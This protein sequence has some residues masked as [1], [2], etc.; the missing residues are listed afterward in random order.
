LCSA[1]LLALEHLLADGDSNA[2]N[3]GNG[4]GFSVQE[5]IDT[6]RRVTGQPIQA[7]TQARRP[8]DPAVLVADSQKARRE[9][10]WEPR[11]EDLGTI[12]EHAWEWE[13]K[14]G[15]ARYNRSFQ[16]SQM[17]GTGEH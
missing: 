6:A 11:F 4:T 15:E 13:R 7:Q 17:D 14:K 5:V 12:V 16:T 10:G 8:G 9:L 1:H 2:F 3:L